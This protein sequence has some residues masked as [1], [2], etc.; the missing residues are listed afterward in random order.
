MVLTWKFGWPWWIAAAAA[1]AAILAA[2]IEIMI[3]PR[4]HY[5]QWRYEILEEEIELRH[6]IF[7]RK[8]TTIPMLRIQ[9]VDTKQ[10]PFLRKYGLATVSF[11][12]AAGSHEIPALTQQDAESVRNQIAALARVS[13]EEL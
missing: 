6:G 8:R 9:H 12:T 7:I 13:D 10:G 4:L 1:G 11:A 3:L 2:I 5:E